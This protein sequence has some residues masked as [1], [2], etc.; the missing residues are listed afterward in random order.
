MHAGGQGFE[1]PHLHSCFVFELRHVEDVVAGR[2]VLL[3]AEPA[4]YHIQ[5]LERCGVELLAGA[6]G[7][8]AGSS[9]FSGVYPVV[10]AK[11]VTPERAGDRGAGSFSR[12]ET[13]E[14]LP[15]HPCRH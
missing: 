2:P 11:M 5:A 13:K 15:K 4:V 12:C 3:S 14:N 10:T 7:G 8:F 6:I 9:A 1:S